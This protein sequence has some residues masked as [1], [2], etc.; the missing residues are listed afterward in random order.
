LG[1]I[2]DWAGKI[3]AYAT[4]RNAASFARPEYIE[5][6]FETSIFNPSRRENFLKG[7]DCER[8]AERRAHFASEIN[9]VHPFNDGNGRVTRLFLKD[10]AARAGFFLDLTRLE[11]DKGAWR[12]AMKQG[13]ERADTSKAKLEILNASR[14]LK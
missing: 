7:L 8:F 12:A 4:G 10:L 6:L 2:Y 9:A 5:S 3:R 1:D 11:A 13:F 14:A